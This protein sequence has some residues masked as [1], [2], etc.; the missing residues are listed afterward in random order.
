MYAEFVHRAGIDRYGR[1]VLGYRLLAQALLDPGARGA[2]VGLGLERREG[3]RADDEESARGIGV[4]Q[5]IDKLTA[6]DVRHEGDLR[7][8]MCRGPQRLDRHRRPQIRSTDADVH[9]ERIGGI[10]ARA[11]PALPYGLG[12]AQ[13]ALALRQYLRID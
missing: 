6:I 4:G 2:R 11:D 10:A 1:K 5:R 9:D 12:K 3:L 8:S 13:H 7:R